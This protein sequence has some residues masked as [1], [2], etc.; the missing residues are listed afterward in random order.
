M[1]YNIKHRIFK[2][3][4][5][6]AICTA[7]LHSIDGHSVSAEGQGLGNACRSLPENISFV[8]YNPAHT[9]TISTISFYVS[10]NMLYPGAGEAFLINTALTFPVLEYQE[11]SVL[12]TGILYEGYIVPDMY[13][14]QELTGI[15]ASDLAN[16]LPVDSF[17]DHLSIAF[18][19]SWQISSFKVNAE[20]G[21][22][23]ESEDASAQKTEMAQLGA[24]VSGSFLKKKLGVGIALDDFL[25]TKNEFDSGKGILPITFGFGLSYRILI[26]ENLSFR[27]S[28]DIVLPKTEPFEVGWGLDA[29]IGEHIHILIGG[30]YDTS[31]GVRFNLGGGTQTSLGEYN[32]RFFISVEQ[33]LKMAQYVDGLHNLS[34]S[35]Q[36]QKK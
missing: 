28:V 26:G 13:T 6:A 32:M 12:S 27:P 2:I 14:D 30:N 23:F 19:V 17:A 31:D 36:I 29:G 25:P 35:V 3:I 4:C 20:S 24:A 22:L 8:G 9:G 15:L 16:Y 21:G 1:I 34:L 7:L 11:K 18:K 33:M 5:T 10:G